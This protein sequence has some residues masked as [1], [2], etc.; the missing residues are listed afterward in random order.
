[1]VIKG[2]LGKLDK[3]A[4]DFA[5]LLKLEPTNPVLIAYVVTTIAMKANTTILP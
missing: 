5:S 3:V 4:E 2:D 1:M